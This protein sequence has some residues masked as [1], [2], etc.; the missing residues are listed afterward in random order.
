MFHFMLFAQ[1]S[2]WSLVSFAGFRAF[3]IY[4]CLTVYEISFILLIHHIILLILISVL[5]V[6]FWTL[7]YYKFFFDHALFDMK[8]LNYLF[9]HMFGSVLECYELTRIS[10]LSTPGNH[11]WLNRHCY[12]IGC[13]IK[14]PIRA[15]V[16]VVQLLNFLNLHF[17]MEWLLQSYFS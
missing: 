11:A 5:S 10:W 7:T 17:I 12:P 15:Y 9:C 1:L 16:V 2:F 3:L 4:I 8:L 6:T 13:V 14:E